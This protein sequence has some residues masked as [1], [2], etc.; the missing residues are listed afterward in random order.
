MAKRSAVELSFSPNWRLHAVLALSMAVP[1]T[2]RAD[3]N[4]IGIKADNQA[5]QITINNSVVL[6]YLLQKDK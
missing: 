5:I 4:A 3:S 1:I 2:S 6:G